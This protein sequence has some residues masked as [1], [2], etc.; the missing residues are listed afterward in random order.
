MST[1]DQ[2]K[3]VSLGID[4]AKNQLG[5]FSKTEAEEALRT[6]FTEILGEEK[7]MRR[8]FRANGHKLFTV[9]EDIL[10]VM[11][12]EGIEDQFADF[13]DYRNVNHGD[14]PVFMVDDYHLFQVA[15]IAAGTNALRRQRLERTGNNVPTA[16]KGIKIYEELERFLAGKVDWAKLISK[17]QASFN[18]QIGA[19]IGAA[20]VSGY[21]A[22]GSPYTYTG[23]WDLTQFNTLLM[24]VEAATQ[25][26][27]MVVGQKLSLQKAVPS[28]VAYNGQVVAD[29]NND[30][31]FK[32]VDGRNF[33]ELKQSHVPGTDTFAIG[34]FLLVLPTT[35][36]KIVKL[37]LEGEPEIVESNNSNN[38]N[39]DDSVEY[40]FKKKY[41][42][43]VLTSTR[44]GVYIPS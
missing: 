3:I 5:N 8:A 32:V 11:I 13:V 9:M 26:E 36:E 25:R 41:G 42:V 35:E 7:N 44:Y 28:F 10:D 40:T 23:T 22:L 33:Y 6:A 29:R 39:A 24:H 12:T 16:Y 31:F 30:G 2:N 27:A 37:V 15:T 38:A 1:T 4:L 43:S 19:D 21:S 14:R 34:N 20:I 18:A 17:V